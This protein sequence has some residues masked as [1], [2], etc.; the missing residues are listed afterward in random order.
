MSA[1]IVNLR[2]FRKGKARSE[3][4]QRAAENR[5]LHGRT[6]AERQREALEKDRVRREVEGARRDGP[7]A[8]DA[9]GSDDERN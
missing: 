5:V 7:G 4:E 6:K 8:A 3:R 9:S 2:R 1:E